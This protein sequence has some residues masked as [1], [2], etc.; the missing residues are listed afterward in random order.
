MVHLGGGSVVGIYTPR[1]S[2]PVVVWC[3]VVVGRQATGGRRKQQRSSSS[4]VA[5]MQSAENRWQAG[6]RPP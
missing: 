3:V 6:S 5:G 1:H 2:H 4:A